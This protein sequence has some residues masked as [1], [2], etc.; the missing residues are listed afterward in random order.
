MTCY[1]KFLP[2]PFIYLFV[3]I[4][5]FSYLLIY[6]LPFQADIEPYELFLQG[7]FKIIYTF[8]IPNASPKV[9]RVALGTQYMFNKWTVNK[10]L[11]SFAEESLLQLR[12]LL[13]LFLSNSRQNRK[14]L[15]PRMRSLQGRIIVT[16]KFCYHARRGK[17]SQASPGILTVN[18]RICPYS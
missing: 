1:F 17:M 16:R 5:V 15:Y 13:D 7:A 12:I 14:T 4:S 6:F 10:I 18:F 2:C 3:F 9:L 11:F 8:S